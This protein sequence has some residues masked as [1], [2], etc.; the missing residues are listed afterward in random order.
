MPCNPSDTPALVRNYGQYGVYV[1]HGDADDN[2][3][4]REAREMRRQLGAFHPDFAYYE[5]PGAGHWWGNECVDWPPL[6]DF[7]RRHTLP[8]PADVRAVRFTTASPGVSAWCHWAAVEAQ[9]KPLQ[10]ST[11]DLR[12]LPSR[13]PFEPR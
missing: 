1:L 3:P 10:P 8:R 13:N 5:R 2:V 11:I 7:L 6:F 9:V 4:V 12:P